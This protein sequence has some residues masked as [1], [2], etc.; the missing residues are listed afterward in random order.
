MLEERGGGTEKA[1]KDSEKSS[2]RVKGQTI[3]SV[4]I[5]NYFFFIG[6]TQKANGSPTVVL[7]SAILLFEKNLKRL[8]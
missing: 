2:L 3:T 1:N 5:S 6:L 7:L 8:K 4:A